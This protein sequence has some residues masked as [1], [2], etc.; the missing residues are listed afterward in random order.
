MDIV[1]LNIFKSQV[2]LESDFSL[3]DSYLEYLLNTAEEVVMNYINRSKDEYK[4]VTTGEY[5]FPKSIQHAV[6]VIAAHWYNQREAVSNTQMYEVPITLTAL[7]KP[8]K[9]LID[10][11]W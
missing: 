2:R 6:L 11:S 10:E 1:A 8:Y 5:V 3:E 7:L 4:D 9:K